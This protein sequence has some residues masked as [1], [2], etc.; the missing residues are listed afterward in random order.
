MAGKAFG[1]KVIGKF[2]GSFEAVDSFIDF[3]VHPSIAHVCSEIV[4]I[5]EFL[6]DNIEFDADV[7]RAIERCAKV[8]V[9]DVKCGEVGIGCGEDAVEEQFDQLKGSCFGAG[10]TW[11]TDAVTTNHDACAIRIR[12][13]WVHFTDNMGVGDV[14]ASLLWDFVVVDGAEGVSTIDPFF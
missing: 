14:G 8:E 2:P 13:L 10:V 4:L 12:L 7:L 3:E 11:V 5:D 6:R 1:E 9:G